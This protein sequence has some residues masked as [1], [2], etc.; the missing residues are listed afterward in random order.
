MCVQVTNLKINCL[1][2]EASSQI[3]RAS[4]DNST[5]VQQFSGA[6]K[7][8]LCILIRLQITRLVSYELGW[9]GCL[10]DSRYK[11][12]KWERWSWL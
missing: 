12:L 7:M 5:E 4:A 1:P 3:C 11:K 6:V 8:E 2:Q 9:D 10:L